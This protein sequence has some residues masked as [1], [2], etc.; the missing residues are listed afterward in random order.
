MTCEKTED[1]IEK[2]L[3]K[4]DIIQAANKKNVA[5]LEATEELLKDAMAINDA[6][7]AETELTESAFM[8]PCGQL[9]VRNILLLTDKKSAGPEANNK[10]TM[11]EIK[12]S[13]L[14]GCSDIANR[15]I[16]YEKWGAIDADTRKV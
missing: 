8:Q 12:A 3:V 10:F 13:Y 5:K 7:S 11:D 6:L 14:Q 2:T 1:G 4:T 16:K 15:P 9:V